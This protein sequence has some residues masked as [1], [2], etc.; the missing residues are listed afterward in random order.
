MKS[1]HLVLTAAATFG[2][3]GFSP[4]RGGAV[5]PTEV[6][7]A[8]CENVAAVGVSPDG[9]RVFCFDK[10]TATLIDLTG[11]KKDKAIPLPKQFRGARIYT[12]VHL[13][14]DVWLLS[15]GRIKYKNDVDGPN[16]R[17]VLF[18]FAAD[19]VK[20]DWASH[21]DIAAELKIAPRQNWGVAADCDE[22]N[23]VCFWDLKT[24]KKTA[25]MNL[26]QDLHLKAP[27]GHERVI[28]RWA[29]DPTSSFLAFGLNGGMLKV[30]DLDKQ[31]WHHVLPPQTGA[32]LGSLIFLDNG[33]LA[34]AWHEEH[35]GREN[36]EIYE[37]KTGKMLF[38]ADA[39]G[40][41][42]E[43][44]APP[45][46]KFFALASWDP[47]QRNSTIRL[48]DVTAKREILAFKA[49][50]DFLEKMTFTADGKRLITCGRDG[51]LKVWD[52]EKILNPPKP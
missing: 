21:A 30:Y 6:I 43:I 13:K 37:W 14:D 20:A 42:T 3:G 28:E 7:D 51:V 5:E 34:A 18:D 31:T 26:L 39:K 29:I 24:G 44:A 27:E 50:D 11:E 41:F 46:G 47:N 25:E 23:T 9:K 22:C 40:V 17:Y 19:L 52:I 2:C 38:R 48:W 35:G 36:V 32:F 33:T 10:W 1:F 12:G 16:N 4:A 8:H 15:V 45:D 49:Y